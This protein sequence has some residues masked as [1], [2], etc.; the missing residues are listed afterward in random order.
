MLLRALDSEDT[1]LYKEKLRE[2][3]SVLNRLNKK[4]KISNSPYNNPL[5]NSEKVSFKVILHDYR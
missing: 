5:K 3:Y 1:T 4:D 2:I